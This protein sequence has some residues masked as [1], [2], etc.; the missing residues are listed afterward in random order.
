M[1]EPDS[2]L[3]LGGELL[4]RNTL[5]N[6]IGH[7]LPLLVAVAALPPTVEG[8]GPERFGI[9]AI[10]LAILG[11][12][13]EIGFGRATTKFVAEAAGND[14]LAQLPGI[15]WGSVAIQLAFGLAGGL[16]LAV[17]APFLAERVLEIPPALQDEARLSLLILAP[18]VPVVLVAAAMRGVLQAAQRFD[19]VNAVKIPVSTAQFLLPLI[20]VLLG[21]S[22][23][24]ILAL[25]LAGRAVAAVAFLLLSLRVFPVLR[26]RLTLAGTNWRELIGFGSWVTVS[27]L[28]SPILVYL[29]RFM[30][31][32]LVTMTAVTY[33][34]IPF[35]ALVR[36]LPVLPAAMVATLFPAFS[37]LEGRREGERMDRLVAAGVKYVLLGV[38]AVVALVV[39]GAEDILMLWMGPEYAAGSTLAMQILAVGFLLN[40]LAFVPQALIQGIGRPDLPAKFH[41][42]ELPIHV[43]LVWVLVEA[44]GVPGAALAWAL[45]GG[46]D[47]ALLFWATFRLSKLSARTLLA[48]R[49]PRAAALVVGFGAAAALSAGSIDWLWLRVLAIVLCTGALALASW[50]LALAREDRSR[51]LGFF[52]TARTGG[53]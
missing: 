19:L 34:S 13:G 23:P 47:A 44:W 24:A 31:G 25:L 28:V 33:Y 37:T 22:L 3:A 2:R 43:V 51:L 49:V 27:G 39:A 42:I 6:L 14:R 20:G 40:A 17:A 12:F 9:L 52:R 46:L 10:A 16:A 38:G 35:E 18:V 45:R 36:V 11:Y 29:D 1:R 7:A 15:V 53:A 21:W 41:L 4:A 26:E 8:L 5:L 48:E 50:K 30:L 32:A